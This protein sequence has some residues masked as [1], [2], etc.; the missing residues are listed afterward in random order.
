[1][2]STERGTSTR[3]LDALLFRWPT[4][5]PPP[6][7]ELIALAADLRGAGVELRVL[8]RP[9]PAEDGHPIAVSAEA[10]ALELDDLAAHGIGPGQVGALGQL[11][12]LPPRVVRLRG[13]TAALRVTALAQSD[14]RSR[15]RV[16]HIDADPAWTLVFTTTDR[17]LERVEEALCTLADGRFG[18]RGTLEEHGPGAQPLVVAA[19]T[20]IDGHGEGLAATP[21][22]LPGPLWTRLELASHAADDTR[23]T[24]DLRTGVLLRETAGDPPLRV[25]RFASLARPGVCVLRAEGAAG[26]LEAGPGLSLPEG[27]ASGDV[28]RLG[29]DRSWAV[30]G[31]PDSWVSGMAATEVRTSGPLRTVERRVV[32]ER[33]RDRPPRMSDS[34]ARLDTVAAVGFEELV[35]EQRRSWA[36]RWQRADITIEG[37]PHLQQAVRFALFHLMSSVADTGEAAV[38]ARGLSGPAYRG[39]VFWDADVFVLPFL[40]ATHPSAARAMLAYRVARLPAAR[41]RAAQ[42][43]LAGARFPWE[44]A[45]DGR[46]VTPDSSTGLDGQDVPILT[47]RYQEHITA[48]VAWAASH[49]LDWTT[50]PAFAAGDG[51]SLLLETARY[52]RSRVTYGHGGRAHLLGVM[53]PDEYHAPVD[54]NA[55]TNEMARWNL[56]RAADVV[57]AGDPADL[58]DEAEAWRRVADGLVDGYDP[59]TGRHQQF[60][61]YDDLEPLLVGDGVGPP[62]A[63]DALLGRDGLAASQVIKQADVLML[64][65]LLAREQPA[66]S[67]QRDLEHYLPRTAHGSSLS[68]GIHAGLLARVGRVDEAL[69]LLQVAARMDLDDVTG[70]TAGGLHLAT[71][72]SVWQALV[73]GFLGVWPERDGSLSVDPHLPPAWR[74]LTVRLTFRGQPIVLRAEHGRLRVTCTTPFDL[75]LGAERHRAVPPG[76]TLDVPVAIARP[77][78]R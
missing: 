72:G 47:G 17:F 16:P 65:H 32:L 35:A 36:D 10:V 7:A 27:V 62:V 50:D 6:E 23:R 69:E 40:A 48:D 66:G 64:H 2:S 77:K 67:L 49:Y 30:C 11:P 12:G 29:A 9:R 1:V 4:A 44:S 22:L 51:R 26:A 28:E 74:A 39:H 24:L 25:L 78:V 75:L 31:T 14:L 33:G 34:R 60:A 38:G 37:D 5:A 41:H 76:T 56:R 63:T 8:G 59:T 19:G 54:D 58:R 46:D 68:P 71:A 57:E 13:G 70:S 42:L 61:G 18:T 53:G 15:G 21:T 3:W 45:D 55:F 43:G 52:W 20:Y 73:F